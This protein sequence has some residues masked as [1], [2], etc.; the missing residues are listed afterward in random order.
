L[1]ETASVLLVFDEINAAALRT[2][3]LDVACPI[4]F[5]GALTSAK[6]DPWRIRDPVDGDRTTFERSFGVIER[7]VRTVTEFVSRQR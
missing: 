6:G 1:I 7:A 2:R 5:L 4:I 3:F